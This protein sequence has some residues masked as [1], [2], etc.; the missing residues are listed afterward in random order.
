ME[1]KRKMRWYTIAIVA[2]SLVVGFAGSSFS[3]NPNESPLLF[4]RGMERENYARDG[5]NLY[6]RTQIGRSSNARY[7]YFGNYIMDG[8]SLFHWDE[9][10][11]NSRHVS[12][13]EANS[14]LTKTNPI[15]ENEYFSQ[16]LDELV[17]LSESNKNFSSR[18]I[19]GNRI[20]VNFSPLTVDMAALNGIRWDMSFS[21]NQVSLISSR[22]D[23]PLWYFKEYVQSSSDL[24]D[25]AQPIYLVGG[26]IQRKLG[27]FNVSANYVNTYRS[28]TT[29]SRSNNSITGTLPDE[30]TDNVPYG[31]SRLPRP[32]QL[33]VKLE[34][35]SSFDA[36]GPRLYDIFPEVNGVARRDLLVG[37]SKGNKQSD[38]LNIRQTD[39]PNKEFYTNRYF[40]DSHRVPDF[41]EFNQEYKNTSNLP[42]DILVKRKVDDPE[43]DFSDLNNGKN[44]IECNGGDYLLLWFTIPENDEIKDIKFKALVDNNYI[45][46]ISEVYQD[47]KSDFQPKETGRSSA[48]Y[49]QQVLFS[50]GDV[51]DGS[52]IS[53]VTFRHGKMMS[54]MLMSFR[55]DTEYKGLKFIGEY[56]RNL[57]F[58]KYPHQKA[59]KYTE[60]ADA[61]YV[62]LMKELGKFTLGLEYFKMDPDYTTSFMNVDPSYADMA[63]S[64]STQFRSDPYGRGNSP[65]GAS[66]QQF[67]NHT[68]FIDT[69]DDNDDKDPYPD[70]H[71]YSGLRDRNGVYP[72][73]DKNGN[74]RP[75]TN[76]N[77]N[78]MPD[79]VE[80]FFLYNVD[81][82]EYDYGRDLN[83]NSVI[84]V[85]EN[86]DKPDYPYDLDRKGHHIF[87]SYG[88][89]MGWKY[90][91]GIMD[92]NKIAAG[93]ET[94]VKYGIAE[95]N[96]F[97]PFFADINFSTTF[98]KV[99]DSI[100]D[101]V[102]RYA[103]HLSTTL[104]DS[105]SY[106]YNLYHAGQQ[107][108]IIDDV[109]A[110]KYYDP[111][112][113]RDSYV[114]KTFFET[115]LFR[116]ENLNIG[117]KLKYDINH[118]N[119][120]SY[121][122]KN[123]IIDRTQIYKADY[124]FYMR[125]LLIQPQVKYLSRKYTNGN[126][127][128]R[129]LHEQY[130]YPIVKVEYPLT[131]KTTF[132]AGVQ[133][134]PGLNAT[135]RNVVNDQL[136]YDTRNTV[137]ML[138]NKSFYS[139]YDFCLN[140]GYKTTWQEF[141]G[142][143]RQAYNRTEKI[144]FVRLI[145]GLEPIS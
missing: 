108:A 114:S 22:A 112:R 26:H 47:S 2:M 58:K 126:G 124:R 145:V 60:N 13:A 138:S 113:Y 29:Q 45:F 111:L 116:I 59:N 141:N 120:T 32:I 14:L 142:L 35:G 17:V 129:T 57:R 54:N 93:G 107:D 43:I 56:S 79:Y 66:P 128:E 83:N 136:D 137:I 143:A 16:Y 122:K 139:G 115:N 102:F 5:Y 105:T 40:L 94:D 39:D 65:T 132:R 11:I 130:F 110:E 21:D 86:D 38:R 95:Y 8:V 15:D 131:M 41:N 9:E 71:L 135:V 28:D 48:T 61:Y 3:Q 68:I 144:Y 27:V 64:W 74:N 10:K 12:G 44:Y 125:D 92:M 62:N 118:Q 70:F 46:S 106:G 51:Q 72:G 53:W 4:Q 121:Q 88:D 55:V 117:M 34:D 87:G 63:D 1:I 103:R 52:N 18:F 98:K 50:T 97:I 25:R 24:L 73:L 81:P 119:E 96:K 101:D 133:G 127:F 37:V 67:M 76:E 49:F 75:D 84:D 69:V 33:V 77:D 90:T 42:A 123:D 91:L 20:R 7:D 82:D 31:S 78:L 89:D 104:V 85:R 140:F 99:N 30:M 100:Q 6:G 23:L 19:V 36:G 134:L 80:P 109:I